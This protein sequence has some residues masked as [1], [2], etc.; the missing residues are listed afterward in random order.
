MQ[1]ENLS[2]F[3][4][5]NKQPTILKNSISIDG[6]HNFIYL[7]FIGI[8]LIPSLIKHSCAAN[9]LAFFVA[10][11]ILLIKS[12]CNIRKNEEIT[13]SFICRDCNKINHYFKFKDKFQY[14]DI[15]LS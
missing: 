4:Y 15:F 2:D 13:C 1:I 5:K 12:L 7:I 8:F 6:K 11:N 10:P 3:N 14:K 9:C